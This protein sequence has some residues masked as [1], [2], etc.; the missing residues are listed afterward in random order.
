[1]HCNTRPASAPHTRGVH[2]HHEEPGGT[3]KS[4]AGV[5]LSLSRMADGSSCAPG[6]LRIMKWVVLRETYLTKLHGVVF[7]DRKRAKSGTAAIRSGRTLHHDYDSKRP[8]PKLFAILTEL[9]T[10][11]RRITVEI[12]EAVEKWRHRDKTRPFIWGSSNYLVKAAGDIEF[13][14]RL[15]GLEE[16]LGVVVTENP[17]LTLTALDGRSTVL[18]RAS[19]RSRSGKFPLGTSGSFGVSAERVAAA[20]AVLYREVQRARRGRGRRQEE[21]R[22]YPDEPLRVDRNSSNTRRGRAKSA[23]RRSPGEFG[24]GEHSGGSRDRTHSSRLRERRGRPQQSPDA[25]GA[26]AYRRTRSPPGDDRTLDYRNGGWHR[27]NHHREEKSLSEKEK[28]RHQEEAEKQQRFRHLGGDGGRVGQHARRRSPAEPEL[29]EV[30]NN[31]RCSQG[32]SPSLDTNPVTIGDRPTSEEQNFDDRGRGSRGQTVR[33]RSSA[34]SELTEPEQDYR[35]THQAPNS[36][37]GSPEQG[38]Q[39]GEPTHRG[40]RRATEVWHVRNSPVDGGR[41]R[42]SHERRRSTGSGDVRYAQREA[43]QSLPYY[44]AVVE[45]H[46]SESRALPPDDQSLDYQNGGVAY[47]DEYYYEEQDGGTPYHDDKQN[48]DY[49][50][51]H[52]EGGYDDYAEVE[53]QAGDGSRDVTAGDERF[54][55]RGDPNHDHAERRPVDAGT[56]AGYWPSSAAVPENGAAA[57]K[58]TSEQRADGLV[59]SRPGTATRDPQYQQR[60]SD[61]EEPSVVQPTETLL[62]V[63]EETRSSGDTDPQD[64]NHGRMGRR[65]SPFNLIFNMCDGMLTDLKGLGVRP[66]GDEDD[67]YQFEPMLLGDPTGKRE[68]N[69]GLVVSTTVEREDN[70]GEGGAWVPQAQ[71]DTSQK[72]ASSQDVAGGRQADPPPPVLRG[73]TYASLT[74][75]I[76]AMGKEG[77]PKRRKGSSGGDEGNGTASSNRV[78]AASFLAW[79]ERTEGRLRHRDAK[80]AKHYRLGRLRHAMSAWETHRAKLLGV[81]MAEAFAGRFGLSSRFF[82]RFTFD[83]LRA[84]AKGARLAAR[85]RAAMGRFISHMERFG[86]GRLRQAWRR[87]APPKLGPEYWG[88]EHGKALDKLCRHWGRGRLKSALGTWRQTAASPSLHTAGSFAVLKGRLKAAGSFA[89]LKAAPHPKTSKPSQ[90]PV[91]PQGG[92]Q[93]EKSTTASKVNSTEEDSWAEWLGN[94]ASLSVVS[95]DGERGSLRAA[96]GASGSTANNSSC[97]ADGEQTLSPSRS[98]RG[99]GA[100]LKSM[101]SFRDGRDKSQVR[102]YRA[103]PRS[104]LMVD[105]ASEGNE[106]A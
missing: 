26:N 7:A 58:A 84:H 12:V 78:L 24:S 43:R 6:E 20:A 79:A 87:W 16:H 80:A 33:R 98:F 93:Q 51:E 13:L 64:G 102:H 3:N 19:I 38:I 95:P 31:V 5:L 36:V 83:A 65:G 73:A 21:L 63:T 59:E 8:S 39:D 74:R 88:A 56:Y 29:T 60:R 91:A 1:M 9:L 18:D 46:D 4:E 30:G 37:S 34:A 77:S 99:L 44:A 100:A 104:I 23:G 105:R 103:L 48:L 89:N 82:V 2:G 85:N 25:A 70:H 81:K 54:A 22:P 32:A 52:Q 101:K 17:F 96:P 28:E 69:D 86:K 41:N 68:R 40:S 11:L 66:D 27:R 49:Y 92:R 71:A 90:A 47:R 35:Y 61:A 55:G 42:G 76:V 57:D 72:A 106:Q 45:K 10:V 15:P 62:A 94:E 67:T 75:G 14:S 97:V 50:Y 53:P